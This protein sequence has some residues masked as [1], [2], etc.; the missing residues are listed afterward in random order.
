MATVAD[1]DVLTALYAPRPALLVYN[2]F[3][4]CCFQTKRARRSIYQ[5]A[6]KVYEPLGAK[7]NIALYDNEDPGTHNCEVDNRR[8][9]YRF[10]NEHFGL[11]SPQDDLPWK[12]EL[13]SE[14]ELTVGLPADNA[15]LYS[16]AQDALKN[17]RARDKVQHSALAARRQLAASDAGLYGGAA[18]VG[19]AG[20]AF[21]GAF[22]MARRQ[23][24]RAQDRCARGT[25]VHCSTRGV[26][27]KTRCRQCV[28]DA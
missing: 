17:V 25:R 1:Y 7:E 5:S 23:V 11:D 9:F 18:A 22:R 28:T 10:L 16:L 21:I 2:R 4:D 20:R 12:D 14:A 6:K 26:C 19:F 27:A 8:Q 13:Y 24:W 3:D 15:T